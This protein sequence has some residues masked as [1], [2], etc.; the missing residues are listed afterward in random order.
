MRKHRCNWR[1][2]VLLVWLI[3]QL[4][5]VVTVFAEDQHSGHSMDHS[6]M[7][8]QDSMSMY[9]V[10]PLSGCDDYHCL[11]CKSRD[12]CSIGGNCGMPECG[13][14]HAKVEC[15]GLPVLYLRSSSGH[16]SCLARGKKVVSEMN[17]VMTLETPERWRFVV[18]EGSQGPEVWLQ[19]SGMSHGNRIVVITDADVEGYRHR[20]KVVQMSH[21]ADDIDKNLVAK[22][23]AALLQ[24]HFD[25]MILG[26]RPSLTVHTH[27][28][29]PLLKAYDAARDL[30]KDGPIPMETWMKVFS[31]KLSPT[32]RD[33]LGVV[34]QIIPKNFTR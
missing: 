25:S 32:D 24:D 30:I 14:E 18:K 6:S 1:R 12:K 10:A 5:F 19:M 4:A 16:S 28:G 23:W 13:H 2:Q 17:K 11:K 34:A 26:K 15:H 20:A 8:M 3:L 31:T 9:S 7:D 22:W 27:C 33:R 21:G 29:K